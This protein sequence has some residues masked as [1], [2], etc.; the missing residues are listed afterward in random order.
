MIEAFKESPRILR[1]PR[2]SLIFIVWNALFPLMD[3]AYTCAFLPGL[4]AAA[5]GYFWIAGPLTLAVLPPGLLVNYIIYRSARRSFQEMG[6]KVRANALGFAL[7]GLLYGLMLQPACLWGY[8]SELCRLPK[9][10]GTK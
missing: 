3:L 10:W 5:F 9:N 7:Y 6:L 4:I 1:V 2:L 8:L